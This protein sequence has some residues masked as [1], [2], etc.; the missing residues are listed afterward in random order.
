MPHAASISLARCSLL[1]ISKIVFLL[2]P[3]CYAMEAGNLE[4]PHQEPVKRRSEPF[5]LLEICLQMIR[6]LTPT[7]AAMVHLDV[8][9][10]RRQRPGYN[11]L[12][13]VLQFPRVAH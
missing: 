6:L 5:H 13:L 2:F 10:A 12:V 4:W 1:F 3:L 8:V 9:A 11:E 7:Q